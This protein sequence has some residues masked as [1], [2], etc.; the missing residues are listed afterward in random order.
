MMMI[1][2]F[3]YTPMFA[4]MDDIA[5]VKNNER[6][7]SIQRYRFSEEAPSDPNVAGVRMNFQGLKM[8]LDIDRASILDLIESSP[9]VL[10][11]YK[12]P[13][14]DDLILTT[15]ACR[16]PN[17]TYLS[18]QAPSNVS[19]PEPYG[20]IYHETG[21]PSLRA[22]RSIMDTANQ[23]LH[24][25]QGGFYNVECHDLV[26]N[27]VCG[28][29]NVCGMSA[30]NLHYNVIDAIIDANIYE[31]FEYLADNLIDHIETH[32]TVSVEE[33]CSFER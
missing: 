25:V 16:V 31:N 14:P 4:I 17:G 27:Q 11:V 18:L 29:F 13:A 12:M 24:F 28:R 2:E 19:Y 5:E 26:V 23:F 30:N 9:F 32:Q 22:D 21:E 15:S 33:L 20:V 7:M 6:S 3:G 1:R 10:A 8:Q